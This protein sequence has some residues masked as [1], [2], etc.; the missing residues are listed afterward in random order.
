ANYDFKILIGE[1]TRT[2][3]VNG[4]PLWY[5]PRRAATGYAGI[6]LGTAVASTSGTSIDFTGIPSWAKRVTVNFSGVSLSGTAFPLIQIGDSGGVET[7]GYVAAAS[8]SA[9]GA[10]PNVSGF[11][12]GF[13][14]RSNDAA[15]TLG[16]S[17]ML[18]L[19]SGT[20]WASSH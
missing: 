16:G 13:G 4:T 1:F 10:S 15:R 6:T 14:I 5:G 12:T 19:V 8:R 11:T 2:G 17:M 3:G 9:D 7:S 18:A 20:T